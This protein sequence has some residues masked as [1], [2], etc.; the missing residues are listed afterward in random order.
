MSTDT[1]EAAFM[2]QA[3]ALALKG[4]GRV[5]PNPMVGCV[6]VK[7]GRL[8]GR[9]F[10]GRFGGPHAEVE[11]LRAAGR[12]ARGATAYVTL[13]PCRHFGKTPPCTQALVR[14]GVRKVVAAMT[15]PDPKVAGKGIAELRRA[16]IRVEVGLLREKARELNRAYVTHRTLGRPYVILKAACSLDGKIGTS[17]GESKW[18]T[19]PA[20]RR[21]AHVLRSQSD[22]ILVGVN[23]ILRDDPELT[24]HGAGRDPVRIVLDTELRVPPKAKVLRPGGPM[25]ILATARRSGPKLR[26]IKGDHVSLVQ[27]RQKDG[28]V[29]LK[30]LLGRLHKLGISTLLVEGGSAVHTS[31]LAD[32][33]V[34]EVRVFV[35]PKLIGGEKA[36][37]LFEGDGTGPLRRAL[38][39]KDCSVRRIGA[40]FLFEGRLD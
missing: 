29:D 39:L 18:I 6:L 2:E 4:R 26:R 14:A 10:H 30:D 8:V 24:S 32:R 21:Q 36:P 35:A 7:G 1:R 3:L 27:A 19:S 23:T 33:L 5:S 22:G 17:S 12:R 37:T 34:D 25:T 28:R 20:S 40:D 13:E 31:F 11:A 16:G 38:R 9:G 15:D